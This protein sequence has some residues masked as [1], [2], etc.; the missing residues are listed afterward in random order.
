MSTLAPLRSWRPR[1]RI[2]GK[3]LIWGLMVL[4]ALLIA[5]KEFH[6][7]NP[8]NKDRPYHIHIMWALIPHLLGAVALLT[9]PLQFSSR[10]RRRFPTLHRNLGK[11][12]VASILI[13]APAAI[14]IPVVG[15]KDQFYTIGIA[16]HASV[17]FITTLIAF[18]MA[19]NGQISLHRQWMIKSYIV[20][21]SFIIVRILSPVLGRLTLAQY[22]IVDVIMSFSYILIPDI[23]FNWRAMTTPRVKRPATNRAAEAAVSGASRDTNATPA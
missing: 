14:A 22:G 1:L 23:C 5:R 15:P 16:V 21:F 9:G 7:L 4:M 8:L 17:W 11:T 12:Y 13:S 2:T 6:Y 18:L 20:T 19:R 10:V 3:T